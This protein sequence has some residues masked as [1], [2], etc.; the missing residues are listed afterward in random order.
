MN[1]RAPDGA[2]KISKIAP[3]A[4]LVQL[5][6]LNLWMPFKMHCGMFTQNGH[7]IKMHCSRFASKNGH[8]A[9]LLQPR[10]L[11]LHSIQV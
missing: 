5:R 8:R 9:A 1:T 7:I 10:H 6:A 4:R 2:N 3:C 11:P